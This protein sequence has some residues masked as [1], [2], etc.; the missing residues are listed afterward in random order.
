MKKVVRRANERGSGE[1]GWLSTR[2]SFSFADWYDPS[3]MGFGALRV[4]NDDTI[5]PNSGF[6]MHSHRKME[7]ITIVMS[8]TLTHKDNL[9]NVGSLRSGEVQV[10]SAGD[11][12]THSEYNASS[13]EPLSL[14]QIW[15]TPARNIGNARYAQAN[16]QD[17]D[18]SDALLPI[19]GPEGSGAPLTMAQDAYISRATLDT[20][21]PFTYE[22][23]KEGSGLF[24]LVIDGNVEVDGE[25]LGRRDALEISDANKITFQTTTETDLLLI[26]VPL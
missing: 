17:L 1:Y 10:M 7:I 2:Y 11:G 23:K 22:F 13:E 20:A 14:F 21:A 3:R 4:L 15:I 9:G 8:G 6:P 18:W 26:E 16:L 25:T 24:V 12:I 19:A 5:A